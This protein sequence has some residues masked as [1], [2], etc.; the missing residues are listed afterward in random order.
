MGNVPFYNV[1]SPN[2]GSAPLSQ[3]RATGQLSNQMPQ[4]GS[5]DARKRPNG[6]KRGSTAS[7][8]RSLIKQK[9]GAV[10]K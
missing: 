1:G 8:Y 5:Y 10:S 6:D 2:G 7:R 9:L 3:N 4:T